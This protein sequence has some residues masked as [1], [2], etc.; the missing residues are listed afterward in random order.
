MAFENVRRSRAIVRLPNDVR[1]M[2]APPRKRFR[3]WH[4][5]LINATG[6]GNSFTYQDAKQLS[7]LLTEYFDRFPEP[8]PE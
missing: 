7:A 2:L 6:T 3:G 5:R 8:P 4:I 1:A